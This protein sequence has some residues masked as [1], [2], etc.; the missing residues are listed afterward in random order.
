VLE[1][2]TSARHPC[3]E[4]VLHG[5]FLEARKEALDLSCNLVWSNALPARVCKDEG[6]RK[7]PRKFGA[8]SPP[9]GADLAYSQLSAIE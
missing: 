4:R 7:L 6:E 5:L 9:P 3:S 8:Y 1:R 2:R